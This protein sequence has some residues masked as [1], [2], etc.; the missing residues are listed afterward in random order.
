MANGMWRLAKRLVGDWDSANAN[1]IE[2]SR[3]VVRAA[4]SAARILVIAGRA[5]S[6]V[7]LGVSVACS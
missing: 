3:R 4:R 1:L 7:F 2:N 5:K 6:A